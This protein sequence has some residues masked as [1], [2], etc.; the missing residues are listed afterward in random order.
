MLL[1]PETI[2][3]SLAIILNVFGI[4]ANL[5]QILIGLFKTPDN[6]KAYV[7]LLVN[8]GICDLVACATA[9]FVQERLELKTRLKQSDNYRVISTGRQLFFIPEG[10]CQHFGGYICHLRFVTI[11]SF[12]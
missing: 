9:L 1:L 5:L 12:H 6:F 10:P 8:S 4:T 11:F 7:V 2:F 3:Y